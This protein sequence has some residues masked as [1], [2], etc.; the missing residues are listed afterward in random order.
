[1]ATRCTVRER[2]ENF[3]TKLPTTSTV[4]VVFT[5]PKSHF[6]TLAGL[7]LTPKHF[8]HSHVPVLVISKKIA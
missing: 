7:N 4:H 3:R 1:M 5:P 8:Y 6:G 2:T